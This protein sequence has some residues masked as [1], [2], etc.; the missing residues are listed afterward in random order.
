MGAH[1]RP[2]APPA[3]YTAQAAA[4][5]TNC[6]RSVGRGG[7]YISYRRGGLKACHFA[8]LTLV[9][10]GRG[11]PGVVE[12]PACYFIALTSRTSHAALRVMRKDSSHAVRKVTE[13]P[14]RERKRRRVRACQRAGAD[15]VKERAR[16]PNDDSATQGW[17]SFSYFR[18]EIAF[19]DRCTVPVIRGG[20]PN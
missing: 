9:D 20:G 17:Q 12:G 8:R 10:T 19:G 11:W 18:R 3:R 5:F 13:F 16:E 2:A 6:T 15:G 14:L 4:K 1:S 7:N